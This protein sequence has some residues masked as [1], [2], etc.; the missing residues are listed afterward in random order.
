MNKD[1]ETDRQTGKKIR[2]ES[3]LPLQAIDRQTDKKIGCESPLPL[4]PI[5]R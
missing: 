1:S 5:D 4:P 2:C 3:P